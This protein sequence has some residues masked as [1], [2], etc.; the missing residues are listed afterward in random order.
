MK[1][2]TYPVEIESMGSSKEVAAL[3][4]EE[5]ETMRGRVRA[6]SKFR[7]FTRKGVSRKGAFAQV[8]MRGEGAI[9]VEFGT[10]RSKPQAPLRKAMRST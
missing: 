10:R 2:V 4:G 9:A 1:A 7:V 5:A 8:I 3:L 6:P